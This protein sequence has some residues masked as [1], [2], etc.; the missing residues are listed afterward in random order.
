MGLDEAIDSILDPL[1]ILRPIHDRRGRLVDF[2]YA[3]ANPAALVANGLPRDDLVGRRLL[4]LFPSHGPSGLFARLAHTFETG[5]P[6]VADDV[7][8]RNDL[9]GLDRLSDV[10]AVRLG[11]TLSYTWRDVTERHELA[12]K[13]R[14]LAAYS[15]DIVLQTDASGVIEWI[16]PSVTA[17]L[18]WR[19]EELVG[20]PISEI[21]SAL[22]GRSRDQY[23]A[24]VAREGRA[25]V[26]L[27]VRDSSGV[28]HAYSASI[29]DVLDDDGRPVARIAGLRNVDDE[30]AARRD[31][32]F[33]RDA[34]GAAVRSDPDPFAVLRA[35]RTDGVVTDFVFV[36]ANDALVAR[37]GVPLDQ[38]VGHSFAARHPRLESSELFGHCA[39]AV[40]SGQPVILSDYTYEGR[41][42]DVRLIPLG[43]ALSCT[44]R[45]VTE[46]HDLLDH[47]RLLAENAS[48]VVFR[49]TLDMDIEW[50]SPSVQELMGWA[51]SQVIG[52]S[53]ATYC[54]PDDIARVLAAVEA[55][56]SGEVGSVE[57]RLLH[58]DGDYRWVLVVGRDVYDDAGQSL[59][60]I[61]S[62]RDL[63]AEHAARVAREESEAR[64][65]LLAENASDVVF[66]VS[67]DFIVEWVS[68]S[69]SE[70]LEW[71]PDQA[72]GKMFAEFCL[73]EDL[74]KLWAVI[75]ETPDD[76]VG[77]AEV[78]VR[79]ASGDYLA[80]GVIGRR[81]TDDEGVVLGYIGSLRD[82]RAE[83]ESRA[84]LVES[85]ARYR[86][87]AENTS[88]VILVSQAGGPIQWVSDS[89]TG[90][91]G[92]RPEEMVGHRF[93]EFVHADDQERL[94]EGR[95][96]IEQGE[97]VL[98]E[99]RVRTS[100]GDYRWIAGRTQDA[101][102]PVTGERRRVNSWRDAQA[103]VAARQRLA[104]S[105]EQYRRLAE[106][107]SDVVVM[108]DN[109][110]VF[111]W[112]SPSIEQVLGWKP[113]ALM[114]R[115]A[116]DF[117]VTD[118][119]ERL[120]PAG[121]A[122]VDDVA[123]LNQVRVRRSDGTYLTMAARSKA[124]FD[125]AA[126][127]TGRVVSF[128]DV[129]A[130]VRARETLIASESRFRLLAENATDVV[131]ELNK[132]SRLVWVSPSLFRV[133]GWRP[134][135]WIGHDTADFIHP[136]DVE[137]VRE[138]R[139]RSFAGETQA[140]LEVRYRDAKGDYHWMSGEDHAIRGR[141]AEVVT[142]VVGLR[143][144][145][146][147]R[148]A[149]ESSAHANELYRVLAENATDV[150]LRIS[151][152]SVIEWIS[153]SVSSV[154][155]YEADQL[156]G[157]YSWMLVHEEDRSRSTAMRTLVL[158]GERIKP[159]QVR[160][161]KGDGEYLWM[162]LTPRPIYG[163]GG[164]DVGIV[165]SARDSQ[166]EVLATRAITT[167]SAVSRALVRAENEQFLFQQMCEIASAEGGYALAWYARKVDDDDH[168]V[169]KFA[170][171]IRNHAYVD[172]I[173]VD[174]TDGPR[175]QGPAGRAIRLGET[176]V[177]NDSTRDAGF[178]PWRD[179]AERHGLRASIGLAVRV[180]DEVDGAFMVYAAES[181]AFDAAAVAVLE[182][183]AAEMGYGLQRLRDRQRLVESLREQKL[184]SRAI[185]QADESVLVLDPTFNILYAN[186]STLRTS[187]YTHEEV[188]GQQP[189]MFG[190]G[191]ASQEFLEGIWTTLS[192]GSAW[193]GTF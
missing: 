28:D 97:V 87:L 158:L 25:I 92:W 60:Y 21:S 47:F 20:R 148:A 166:A 53:L 3:D 105:E 17:E 173:E 34:F 50:I 111:T 103:D 12:E 35:V 96:R 121:L 72:I 118:D 88:D 78:R 5:E 160:V 142:R 70:L 85:E 69:I 139:R 18:G 14:M 57:I 66:R 75:N 63:E 91:V 13:Y 126:T 137:L 146:A 51:P 172:E 170:S 114:G 169:L 64:Y 89:V 168:S 161:R 62:F 157:T 109:D 185:E 186:P 150:V 49:A 151:K 174:W 86:L 55:V 19:P 54:H 41:R 193:R 46:R 33:E 37:E 125:D 122:S 31:L 43:D 15:S 134:E 184:L 192:R 27:R 45:D 77:S 10:R 179:S 175:G 80:V 171:S 129:S 68:P 95:A 22:D 140:P 130:E 39:R 110:L 123:R 24:A 188:I 29:H 135:E 76:Q 181:D 113:G 44:W 52:R 115:H 191:L 107:A 102:D 16:S 162:T 152:E 177:N 73:P 83:H 119:V 132:D 11:D 183:M 100:T 145:D 163:D 36:D 112:V 131:L 84:A 190:A 182:D 154:L 124:T 40:D 65:R 144:V 2:E 147:E 30:V 117:L 4:E 165:L 61:G 138:F 141:S 149:R 167:M 108:L 120:G 127:P 93:A 7:L 99:V 104:D 180:G 128:R 164:G 143:N 6:L 153:P 71:Q 81:L 26:E 156:I 58:H 9:T 155:G 133:L 79:R 1:V 56:P 8:H 94:S 101:D 159:Y 187:G 67:P 32:E 116:R 59:G 82:V 38:L 74:D 136:D 98:L 106:N 178:A 42:L 23:V 176:I 189:S 90:L 48:D